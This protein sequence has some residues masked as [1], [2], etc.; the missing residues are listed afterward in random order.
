MIEKVRF[1]GCDWH[2]SVEAFPEMKNRH[3]GAPLKGSPS[4]TGRDEATLW[5]TLRPGKPE[6]R[7]ANKIPL[8]LC[9]PS[10]QLVA[11]VCCGYA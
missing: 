3:Q 11:M 8:F 1:I 2:M 10:S 7:G 6:K 5:L 9:S 4:M